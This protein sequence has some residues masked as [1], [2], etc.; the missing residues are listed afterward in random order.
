MASRQVVYIAL[1][2][3]VK[4]ERERGREKK[5]IT[6]YGFFPWMQH[7]LCTGL[8]S[9]SQPQF[10]AVTVTFC[11]LFWPAVL[12][13]HPSVRQCVFC[14]ECEHTAHGSCVQ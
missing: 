5:F 2:S 6:I 10:V 4:L 3:I 8:I 14:G 9:F 13:A 1:K 7:N 12:F 11:V